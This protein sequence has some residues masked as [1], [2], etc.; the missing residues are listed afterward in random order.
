M[1]AILGIS[2]YYHDSAA[3]LVVDGQIVAAAQEERFSR[4]KHDERFPQQAID[5]CLEHAG[6]TPADLDYVGFYEKPLSRFER[7]LETY[8]AYAPRGYRSFR[9]ALPLWLSQKLHLRRELRRG[10]G[11]QYTGRFVFADHHQSHA[12]SAFFPSPFDEAAI[13]TVDGVGEWSTTCFGTGH[14]NRL[15]LTHELRFP[16]SLGL[17]YSALTYYLG[18]RVNSGE[19]KVMGLAPYGRPVYRDLLL[20]KVIDLKADGSFRLD[21]SYFN[22]CQGLTMTSR[23]LHRLL[24]GPPRT[25]E[26][27]IQE[28]HMD[29]AASIQAVAEEI[30]LRMARHLHQQT[31]RR[32]LV[33]AGGVALNCVANGRI[34]RESGFEH[35]WVQ[36]AAGDAGGALGVA[37]LIWFQL[38]EKPRDP[39]GCDMQQGSFLGPEFTDEQIAQVLDREGAAYHTCADDEQLVDT[40]ARLIAQQQVVG[41]FQG[42]MEFGPRALGAR[43]ILGDPRSDSMQSVMNQKIKFRESFR[44]FAPCVLREHVEQYF[45]VRPSEDSPYMLLVAP[46]RAEHRCPMDAAYEAATG[47]EKL[48]VRRSTIPA[49]T[50]VD[51]SARIQTVDRQ[52]HP[53]L[54]QLLTRFYEQTGCP[55]LI[56][57]SFNVRGEPLVC[58][59][60][61]AYRCFQMT[62]MDA[63]VMGRHI[64]LKTSQRQQAGSEQRKEYLAQFQPD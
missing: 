30:L 28:R 48:N 34:L 61:E 12:A 36:P 42:R 13:L 51:G 57:T 64:I 50:H 49:V 58:T 63:L 9:R 31:G 43:S 41:W 21:M 15:K 4:Q 38:L 5:Y 46:V 25:P 10:L 59:P 8:L 39:Q 29:L 3:A 23:K 32:K 53:L 40:V 26:S 62:E 55:L 54:H 27:P 18:F 22:Y 19:Y 1:T 7:L 52:R 11:G 56:N 14:G 60:Q 37:L 45:E 17:L 44:P 20:E 24:G 35:L 33:M 47:F 16:H 6:L 2:A